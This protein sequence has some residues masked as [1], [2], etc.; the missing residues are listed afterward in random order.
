M[1]KLIAIN[2]L[3][4]WIKR[5]FVN[6]YLQLMY[7]K[8]HL[9]IGYMCFVKNCSFGSR[10]T[11]YDNVSLSNVKLGDF[12][13]I[14]YG[15]RVNNATLGK[16]CSIGPDVII[17]LGKHPTN[18]FVTTH[19]SFYSTAKQAQEAFC[20]KDY[21]DEFEPVTIGNDVWIG[22]RSVVLDGININDGVIVAAGSVVTKDVPPFAIVGGIPAKIIKYRFTP[23]QI[24][25]LR[26]FMWW[27]NDVAWLKRHYQYF[28]DIE[29]FVTYMS[30]H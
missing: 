5:T 24:S 7:A 18:N 29:A 30:R 20:N 26:D 22:A 21:Y 14:S 28:H 17:G 2:P 4:I 27:N 16:Y 25:F 10:N 9:K 19:P 6:L 23:M 3:F 11:I 8:K 1:I 13:Y 15:S 12:T